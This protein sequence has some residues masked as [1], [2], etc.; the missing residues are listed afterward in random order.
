MHPLF[1]FR[2]QNVVN[3]P[4]LLDPGLALK[5]RCDNFDAKV[6]FPVRT[7]PR[8]ALVLRRF[9]D[10]LKGKGRKRRLQLAFQGF[11]NQS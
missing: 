8:M 6:A 3:H 11:S 4:V 10:H 2:R 1:E 5:R 7:R 9:I